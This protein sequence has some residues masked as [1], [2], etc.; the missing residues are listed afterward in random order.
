MT[1]LGDWEQPFRP[2]PVM[3]YRSVRRLLT[4]SAAAWVL[5][6]AL[7][8]LATDYYVS[9]TGSDSAAGTM[10][11]PFATLQKGH[12]VSAA[13]DTVWIHRS[14]EHTSELQSPYVISY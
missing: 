6:F 9:P 13:G 8:A 1:A 5:T 12:D 2:R 11:A 14:E 4:T 10:D 3:S 7:D